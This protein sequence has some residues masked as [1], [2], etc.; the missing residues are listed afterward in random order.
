MG[1]VSFPSALQLFVFL[2]LGGGMDRDNIKC[3]FGA[4][5]HRV[6]SSPC[7]V[8]W[9]WSQDY[10]AVHSGSILWSSLTLVGQEC[11]VLLSK[12]APL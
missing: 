8:P 3:A 1:P 6:N 5:M 4:G 10:Y 12:M 9:H 11:S 7:F 2:F